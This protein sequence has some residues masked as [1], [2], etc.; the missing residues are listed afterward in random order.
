MKWILKQL[1]QWVEATSYFML[2]DFIV[3]SVY[4]IAHQQCLYVVTF[5]VQIP[6]SQNFLT[7]DVGS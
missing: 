7:L 4:D 5:D 6:E 1:Q 2:H 3:C